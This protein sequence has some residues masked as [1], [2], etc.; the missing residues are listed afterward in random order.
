MSSAA[1]DRLGQRAVLACGQLAIRVGEMQLQAIL[2]V[3]ER[4]AT[5]KDKK[6]P[7]GPMIFSRNFAALASTVRPLKRAA[8]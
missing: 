6:M 1:S 7:I 2:R 3:D 4:D 8:S 5:K